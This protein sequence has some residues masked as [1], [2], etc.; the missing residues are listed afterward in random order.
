MASHHLVQLVR[1]LP[2]A[3]LL[4]FYYDYVSTMAGYEPANPSLEVQYSICGL[5]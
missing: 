5:L 4:R 1:L 2:M 3:S